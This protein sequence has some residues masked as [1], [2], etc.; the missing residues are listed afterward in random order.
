M[1]KTFLLAM[2]LL[3]L[4]A[5]AFA[6]KPIAPQRHGWDYR[7]LL[8]GDVERVTVSSYDVV[9]Q[10]GEFVK[11]NE[12]YPK[13]VFKFN[14]RGDVSEFFVYE[15]DT[16]LMFRKCYKYDPQGKCI[17]EVSYSS[18][19]KEVSK[20]L[21]VYNSQGK[22][23]E[24]YYSDADN[25]PRMI[26][27]YDSQGNCIEM[28]D[29]S[30]HDWFGGRITYKYDSQGNMIEEAYYYRGSLRRIFKYDSQGN[31]T[32]KVYNRE[33]LLTGTGVIKRNSQGQW[34]EAVEYDGAGALFSKC[35]FK[36]D[37]HGNVVEKYDYKGE[38]MQLI[39]VTV[40]EIVYRK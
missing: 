7:N 36:L 17:E 9:E 27:K 31:I 16:S 13:N 32:G 2:L 19:G 23:V 14:E 29:Y 25:T 5:D 22:C 21:Y 28:V 24:E 1:K 40:L 34:V 12:R 4:A 26:F 11:G 10:S 38:N 35:I 37:S 6:Q 30:S 33:G 39:S 15:K 20:T 8:F 3:L 18:N